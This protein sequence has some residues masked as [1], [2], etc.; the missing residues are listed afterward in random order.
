MLAKL[1]L[2][3]LGTLALAGAYVVHEGAV[4]VAVDEQFAGGKRVRLLVPAAL[5][6]VGMK[7]VPNQKLRA[8]AA[9]AR[10]WL[11]AIGVASQELAHLPDTKLIEVRDAEQHVSVLKLGAL[12]VLDVQSPRETIHVSLPLKTLNK[13]VHQLESLGPAP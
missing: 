2:G 1:T 3:A 13:V 11:P 4:R 9:Q 10:P 8:A 12:L 7:F 5:V 6:P